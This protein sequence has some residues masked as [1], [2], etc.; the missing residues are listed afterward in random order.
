[1]ELVQMIK[2]MEE[3]KFTRKQAIFREGDEPNKIY[4]IKKGE[5]ELQKS[6]EKEKEDD[7]DLPSYMDPV[8]PS[9]SRTNWTHRPKPMRVI[10]N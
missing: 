4:F 10:L 6:I 3:V 5:I 9:R 2:C 1:M 7:F 8:S